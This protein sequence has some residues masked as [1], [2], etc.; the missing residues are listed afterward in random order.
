[1][2]RKS[3]VAA[4]VL[5]GIALTASVSVA[6]AS[7]WWRGDRYVLPSRGLKTAVEEVLTDHRNRLDAIGSGPFVESLAEPRL[8]CIR[9]NVAPD[10]SEVSGLGFNAFQAFTGSYGV[11]FDVPF[12][13]LPGVGILA[14][15]RLTIDYNLSPELLQVAFQDEE[16]VPTNTRFSFVIVGPVGG[17]P[18]E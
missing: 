16:G 7:W 9:G 4:L 11:A 2:K 12:D 10:G 1:M 18:D 13:D 8:V 15:D 3:F 14:D 17:P 6:A 5:S